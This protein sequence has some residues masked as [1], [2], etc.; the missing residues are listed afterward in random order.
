LERPTARAFTFL[1]DGEAEELRWDYAELDLRARAIAAH[2]Q[3]I[4]A[5]G[6]RV[7]LS[8]P[9]GLDFIAGFF[10]CLYAGAVAVP[11]YPNRPR[12]PLSHILNIVHDTEAV[13]ALTTGAQLREME[14]AL[15]AEPALR[16]L[17]WLASDR[18][19]MAGATRWQQPH[20]E[21]E[22]LAYIQYT[23]GST[24]RPKGVMISHA[25]VIAN[26]RMIT[27]GFEHTQRLVGFGWLPLYHD[28][29]LIG[30]V[31]QTAYLGRPSILM[32][33]ASFLQQPLRWLR[34]HRVQRGGAGAGR[35]NRAI[36]R[37]VRTVWLPA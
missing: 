22:S 18:V 30:L 11:T 14:A 33:P 3:G 16:E 25:N 24:G 37:N 20:I 26:Q 8:Y 29:G 7:L 2:L 32:A 21:P 5:A 34:G 36:F 1:L 28:M 9:P 19:D 17:R 27:E 4:G 31:L 23:S 12:R 35:R 15:A 6:Q 13:A 10:G